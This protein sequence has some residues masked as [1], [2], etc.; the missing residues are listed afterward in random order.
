[1]KTLYFIPGVASEDQKA[2]AKKATAKIRNSAAY[3]EGDYL[4]PCDAVMGD[5][6][7]GYQ[8]IDRHELDSKAQKLAKTE[9]EIDPARSQLISAAL[10]QLDNAND[11]HWTKGGLPDIKAIEALMGD[12]PTTR[13]EVE[14]VAPDLKRQTEGE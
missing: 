4:E 2:L 6:P 10:A 7:K 1:M 9:A 12:K 5:V 14:A 13:A 11:E 3:H 8:D